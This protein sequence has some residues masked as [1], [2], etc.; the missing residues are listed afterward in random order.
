MNRWLPIVAVL[1]LCLGA[2]AHEPLRP[3]PPMPLQEEAAEVF[4][5]EPELAIAGPEASQ[6]GSA[7][8]LEAPKGA[9]KEKFYWRVIPSGDPKVKASAVPFC[10]GRKV[11]VFPTLGSHEFEVIRASEDLSIARDTHVVVVSDADVPLP[12]K[13]LR[14]YV[15]AQQAAD[16]YELLNDYAVEVE[17]GATATTD[18]FRSAFDFTL[19]SLKIGDI[20]KFKAELDARLNA[21]LTPAGSLDPVIRP[22]LVA[23]LRKATAELGTTPIPPKPPGPV[24]VP[25]KRTIYIVRETER[26]HNM[27]GAVLNA[28]RTGAESQALAA[29]GHKLLIADPNDALPAGVSGEGVFIIDP[30]T[31]TVVHQQGLPTKASEVVDA[32][33]GH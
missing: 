4:A 9:G 18:H 29:G 28:L 24:V 23:E 26:Q 19:N 7:L 15:T 16:L 13:T 32:L 20:S 8:V 25:G 22:L 31:K 30:V 5:A 2:D 27:L 12:S 33:K 1:V 10:A 11:Y 21:V 6:L 14:D 17:N 3:I